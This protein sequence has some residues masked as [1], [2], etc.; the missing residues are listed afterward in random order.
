MVRAALIAALLV[1][2][3]PVLAQER[4]LPDRRSPDV[5]TRWYG[6]QTLLVDASAVG[7]L[8]TANAWSSSRL[9]SAQLTAAVGLYAFGGP[10]VHWALHGRGLAGVGDLGLRVVLVYGS[11]ALFGVLASGSSSSESNVALGGVVFGAVLGGVTASIIDATAISR[12]PLEGPPRLSL[13]PLVT[14]QARGLA[15]ALRL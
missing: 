4:E 10:M 8:A 1:A 14:P 3:A 15:L 5:A 12:E 2:S 6:W 9:Q 13:V 7:L 11:A